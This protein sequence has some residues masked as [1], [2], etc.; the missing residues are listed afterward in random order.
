M[1]EADQ[2]RREFLTRVGGA[3]GLLFAR[4]VTALARDGE[5][6][7]RLVF[8]DQTDDVHPVH[9]HRSSFELTNVYGKQTTGVMKDVVLVKG[10]QKIEADVTP[11]MEGLTLFHCHQQLHMDYGLKLLFDVI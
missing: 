3:A 10:Y 4:T 2:R 5:A 8:D 11:L 1:R 6:A 7:D 9:L